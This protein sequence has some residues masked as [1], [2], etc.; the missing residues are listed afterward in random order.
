MQHPNNRANKNKR[1]CES[2][3]RKQHDI[4]Y[5][6]ARTHKAHTFSRVFPPRPPPPT[7]SGDAL[8]NETIKHIRG[9]ARFRDCLVANM[10]A[11][12]CAINMAV[13]PFASFT[14]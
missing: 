1:R 8:R 4:F 9:H 14:R 13:A 5:F 11:H 7:P 12:M 2:V 3:L 6:I 10:A